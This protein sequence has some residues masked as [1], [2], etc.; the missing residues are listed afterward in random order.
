MLHI[1]QKRGTDQ[2]AVPLRRL[3]DIFELL[4]WLEISLG[5][6]FEPPGGEGGGA[7]EAAGVD[8]QNTGPG[9]QLP[10]PHRHASLAKLHS[11][12]I[13]I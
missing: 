12:R 7:V 2:Y 5:E 4:W 1:L 6:V 10:Q 8:E 9:Q 3:L 13:V 11:T